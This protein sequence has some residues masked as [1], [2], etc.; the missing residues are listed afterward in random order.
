MIAHFK[1]S[2]F[3]LNIDIKQLKGFEEILSK[4]IAI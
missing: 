1:V 2:G 3:K 4:V